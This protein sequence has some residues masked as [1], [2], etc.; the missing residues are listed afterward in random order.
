[1]NN[2]DIAT[3]RRQFKLDHDLMQIS[4]IFNVYILKES[5]DIYHQESQP[6]A[7]L[8][9]DQQELYLSNFKKLLSGS[10][11]EKL[12]ELK[13]QSEAEEHSQSILYE[14]LLAKHVEDW[15][16]QMLRIVEKMLS[17]EQYSQDRVVTFIRGEYFKPTKS[18]SAEVEESER[19]EVYSY[20]FV[21]CSINKT[22]QP[23]KTLMFDYVEKE[24]K[25]NVITDPIIKL[26]SPETGF[27]FPC[28]TNHAADVHHILY[29]TGKANEPDLHFIENVL[30]GERAMTAQEE[31][32]VFE[33]IVKE[34]TGDKLDTTTLANVYEKINRVIHENDEEDT[35]KLDYKDV[36]H[37]LMVSGVED[38]NT[39]KVERAF[40][41]IIDDRNYELKAS[42]LIPKYTSKSIKIN[43][44]VA[45]ISVSP[46]DLK[47][48]K[49]VNYKGKRC[50]LIE[51]DEDAVIEGF[52]M[53]SETIH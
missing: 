47:Y 51:V 27:L 16:E 49:Q 41:N 20:R 38:V 12:F 23:Q 6:F 18:R 32:D 33:E 5:S 31:R 30:N 34:V 24:F 40:Q 8:D 37:V 1:M 3:I 9:R 2:K 52:T 50:I 36:E 10:L 14:G 15:K 29:S 45:S 19:D 46:Q 39:E 21:L 11:D 17:D 48:V 28:F 25:S 4:D 26:T 44:K 53:N 35:P 43:T 13:F 7:M 42:S 22:E